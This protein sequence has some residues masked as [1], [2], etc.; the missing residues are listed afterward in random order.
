MVNLSNLI[1]KENS[2]Y[3]IHILLKY[4]GLNILSIPLEITILSRAVIIICEA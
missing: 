1:S 3:I 4:Y 2:R